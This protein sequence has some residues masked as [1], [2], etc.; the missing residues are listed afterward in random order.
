MPEKAMTRTA[1]PGGSC[2]CHGVHHGAHGRPRAPRAL[3]EV[4]QRPQGHEGL[5]VGALGGDALQGLGQQALGE[6]EGQAE[7][8]GQPHEH[9][10]AVGCTAL[11]SPGGRARGVEG[12]GGTAPVGRRGR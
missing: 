2:C 11:G 7:S 8:E 6:H 12:L 1:L 9:P 4:L 3:D 5:P 10:H